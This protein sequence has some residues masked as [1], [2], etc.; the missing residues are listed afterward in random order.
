MEINKAT[1]EKV[2]KT[3][4]RMQKAIDYNDKEYM[5]ELL[6]H[7]AEVAYF[8]G[9]NNGEERNSGNEKTRHENTVFLKER[10]DSEISKLLLEIG[11]PAHIKGH[12]YLSDAIS[13]VCQ[14]FSTLSSIT[15]G[16]YPQIAK[17]YN[18]TATRVERAIRHAIEIA[19]NRGDKESMTPILGTAVIQAN[20]KPTNSE[21]LHLIA[22]YIRRNLKE[23]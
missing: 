22:D 20:V 18:T 13:I 2:Q 5:S 15:K 7:L 4:K 11:V 8:E 23:K 10:L 9:L 21:Y 3:L 16:I 19:W 17:K 1:R 6:Y 14:D 12:R